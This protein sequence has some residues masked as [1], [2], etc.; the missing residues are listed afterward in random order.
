MK[1]PH[2]F[3]DR[4]VL[5]MKNKNIK[6]VDLVRSLKISKGTASNWYSGKS[7]PESPEQLAKLADTLGITIEW[8]ATGQGQMT[9][10]NGISVGGNNKN[11]GV[12]VGQM[13]APF[14]PT[15]LSSYA[16]IGDWDDNTPLDG[17][18]VEL[19]FYK[20][21]AFACGHGAEGEAQANEWRKLRFSRIT[22]E[23]LG[24]YKDKAFAAT[25][26]DDSMM[27]TICDGDTIFVDEGRNYIKDG[28]IFAI[29][30]GGLFYCKR[31]YNLPNGG[32]RIV[33]DNADEFPEYSLSRDDIE[34][35][36]FRV[37]GW[38]FSV[39]RLER[40]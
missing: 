24:I 34:K 25:A 14:N 31:L 29:E 1:D 32:V 19:T 5:A 39:S 33:S 12:Q 10:N 23:R 6:Q 37:I 15:A 40:W 21:L 18:E 17:D 2:T 8:L 27:P 20:K 28:R 3:Q 26:Q 4:L 11:T 7:M 35:D 9:V 38:V 22:L 13:S 30:H 16:T 36:G